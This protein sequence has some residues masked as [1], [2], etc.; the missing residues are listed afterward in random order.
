[1]ALARNGPRRWTRRRLWFTL[2]AMVLLAAC[3]DPSRATRTAGSTAATPTTATP[4]APATT[5]APTTAAPVTTAAA[6]TAPA[7]APTT[8]VAAVPASSFA[9]TIS[10]V[11]AADL[12][13]S[14]R[15]G[16][17]VAPEDLRV[18]RVSHWGFDD[19]S[20]R[21]SIVVAASVADEVLQVFRT[22]YDQR[23]PIRRLEPV[24][25]FGGDDD[26]SMAADNTSGFNCRPAVTT[27][28]PHWS[29]HAYGLA[30][31]V[32]P[33]ENPYILG[34]QVLPPTGA[35]FVDRSPYR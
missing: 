23:F 22:L 26:A 10:A 35:D 7:G 31:D 33:V 8:T 20:R 11:T 1:M 24:D 29:N 12:P 14:W 32:N 17:P 15:P 2:T 28:P 19:Q 6:P 9:G 25:A 16:C 34:G 5:T 4:A 18:L 27:G 30:I 3:S 13:S 21:G